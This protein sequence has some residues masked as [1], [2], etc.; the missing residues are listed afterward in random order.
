MNKKQFLEKFT[1]EFKMNKKNG[2]YLSKIDVYNIEY[3]SLVHTTIMHVES[4]INNTQFLEMEDDGFIF[5]KREHL[6]N[7]VEHYKISD[8][9][10]QNADKSEIESF[11]M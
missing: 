2:L 4:T 5:R 9:N 7:V 11:F 6:K 8:F 10:P 1:C 3:N